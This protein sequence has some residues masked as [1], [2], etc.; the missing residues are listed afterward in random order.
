MH[1]EAQSLK[2]IRKF[3]KNRQKNQTLGIDQP[4]Y[5]ADLLKYGDPESDDGEEPPVKETLENFKG[6]NQARSSEIFQTL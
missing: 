5:E 6:N 1:N 3:S 2:N 4:S